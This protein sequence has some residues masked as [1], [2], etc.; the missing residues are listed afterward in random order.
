MDTQKT[1]PTRTYYR[2][3]LDDALLSQ[4]MRIFN[5]H[6]KFSVFIAHPKGKPLRAIAFAQ[7]QRELNTLIRGYIANNN[8]IVFVRSK[9]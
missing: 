6:L 9:P 2:L 8:S 1:R 7:N 5:Q 3:D 4:A